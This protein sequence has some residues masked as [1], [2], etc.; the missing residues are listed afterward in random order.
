MSKTGPKGEPKATPVQSKKAVVKILM[1]LAR[2]LLL[3]TKQRNTEQQRVVSDL[4]TNG[5]P[6]KFI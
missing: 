2:C 5:Y 6:A 4:K 3:I 1:D